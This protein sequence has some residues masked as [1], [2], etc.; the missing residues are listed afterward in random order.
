M[1]DIRVRLSTLW[2]FMLFNF[3]YCDVMAVFDPTLPKDLT[4]EALLAASFL[5]EIPIAMV[6]L[7]RVLKYGPNRWANIIAGVFMAVVQ[8]S[9][10]FVG[11]GPTAYYVFFSVIE[12]ACLLFIVWSAWRWAEPAPATAIA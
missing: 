4:R 1:Q 11:S 5:M 7:S 8:V 12:I 6:L 3:L 2:V 10:L 9:T